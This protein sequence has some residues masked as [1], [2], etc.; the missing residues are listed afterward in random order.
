MADLKE[1]Y[2]EKLLSRLIHHVKA[3]YPDFNQD[4]FEEHLLKEEWPG[5]A[6]KERMRRITVSLYETLPKHFGEAVAILRDAAPHFKG[7]S[8]ILFPDYVEQYGLAHWDESIHAL[9]YFTQYSTSEFAVRPFLLLDQDKMIAQLLAWSEHENEHVRRLAS[10][11]SRPRLPW[12]KSIPALK[13]DPSPVLPILENLMQD[14]SLY[15]RKSVANNLNDISKT[16]SH[17][18]RKVADQW[19]GTH[20]YSDWIIK[21]AYRTLLKKGDKQALAL[22]G[23]ENADSI[24]IHDLTCQ[25]SRIAIGESIA[26]SFSVRSDRDQKV[27][28]EYAIDFVKARGQRHQKIFKITETT[29]RKNETKSYTKNHS[30]KD[31]TTRKH[32]KGTHTLSVIINGETKDS[33]DFEIC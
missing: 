11:G 14:E 28:I 26:F 31:L 27:R 22:F 29:I 12:G 17:L 13:S 16:H 24:Q 19:Y 18:L 21:H 7:L 2:N 32:Y 4:R 25:P 5:L 10:E 23:Y 30:F 33:L 6:L 3:S 1:I 20:P 8:G 9:E 15:V